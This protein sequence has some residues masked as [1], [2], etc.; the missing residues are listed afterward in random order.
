MSSLQ[1][2]RFETLAGNKEVAMIVAAPGPG[3]QANN[4]CVRILG[5][6]YATP[7]S[8]ALRSSREPEHRRVRA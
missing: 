4:G 8:K 6:A 2:S 7:E 5:Q 1:N 3:W